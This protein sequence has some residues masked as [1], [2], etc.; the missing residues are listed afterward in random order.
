[1]KLFIP[2]LLLPIV[3]VSIFFVPVQVVFA[4]TQDSGLFNIWTGTGSGGETC[5]VK[6]PCNFCDGIRVAQNIVKALFTIAIPIAVA[7]IIY[8]AIRLMISGGS[9]EQVSKSKKIMT[10][11]VIGLVIA[12]AAW[13]IINT[14]F[15]ILTGD[16]NFPWNS[17]TCS[18]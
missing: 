6:G 4:D 12:L 11:A 9:E 17:V 8:G 16:V 2:T 1:M 5:N 13:I 3:L 15:H 7:M 18:S 14:L 10:S